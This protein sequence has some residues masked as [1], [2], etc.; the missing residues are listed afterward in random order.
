MYKEHLINYF[1]VRLTNLTHLIHFQVKNVQTQI[2]KYIFQNF[3]YCG[4]EQFTRSG[5]L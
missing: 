3:D 5:Y 4:L 1:Y 2:I